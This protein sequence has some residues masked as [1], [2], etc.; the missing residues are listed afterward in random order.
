MGEPEMRQIAGWMDQVVAAP[1]DEELGER[2]RQEVL[3]FCKAF[4]T[5]SA[6]PR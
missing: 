1:D 6:P 4:P 2:V 3:E 5:P